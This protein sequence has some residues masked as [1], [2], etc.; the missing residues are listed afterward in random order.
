VKVFQRL[1]YRR[2]VCISWELLS[3]CND[4]QVVVGD[5][6]PSFLQRS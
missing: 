5:E 3:I 4:I 1:R 2:G 6:R